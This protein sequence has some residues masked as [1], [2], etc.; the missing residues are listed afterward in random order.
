MKSK[1]QKIKWMKKKKRRRNVLEESVQRKIKNGD[2]CILSLAKAVFW[3][4][5]VLDT[6]VL[7]HLKDHRPFRLFPVIAELR[8]CEK[9]HFIV[10]AHH[11]H[12]APNG[13]LRQAIVCVASFDVFNLYGRYNVRYA[14]HTT[15]GF[16][17]CQYAHYRNLVSSNRILC[18]MS[19]LHFIAFKWMRNKAILC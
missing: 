11:F 6:H 1:H 15:R 2:R 16:F 5:S 14:A 3:R 10:H 7:H 17:K 18:S 4:A 9:H 8:L 19:S 13:I 12:R